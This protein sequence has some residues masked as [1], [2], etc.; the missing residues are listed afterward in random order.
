M[1]YMTIFEL[2]LLWSVGHIGHIQVGRCPYI[3][4]HGVG[5][6][7]YVSIYYCILIDEVASRM[8]ITYTAT[9]LLVGL[10]MLL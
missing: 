9:C 1:C 10:A 7:R 4:L 2:L 5:N 6:E 8:K 3:P